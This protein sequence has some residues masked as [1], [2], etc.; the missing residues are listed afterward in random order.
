MA[1]HQKANSS[2]NQS[3]EMKTVKVTVSTET[4]KHE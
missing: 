1:L 4:H 3:S 2:T